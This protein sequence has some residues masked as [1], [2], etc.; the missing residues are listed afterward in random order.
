MCVGRRRCSS[1]WRSRSAPDRCSLRTRARGS[2]PNNVPRRPRR[3]SPTRVAGS[4]G[5]CSGS[6]RPIR[7]AGWRPTTA[8][9]FSTAT[10]GSR[11]AAAS[12]SAPAGA[13]TSSIATRGWTSAAASRPATTRCCRR[14]SRC[15]TWPATA[16]SS[17][18]MPSIA[19]TRRKISGESAL[20]SSPDTRRVSFR[21]DY[22][23]YEGRAIV[24]PVQLAR[25]R[26]ALRAPATAR[27]GA[28]T[29]S[30]LPVDPGC[31]ARARPRRVSTRSRTLTPFAEVFGAVDYRDQESG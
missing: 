24:R 19:T 17:A 6:R 12:G 10:S 9:T 5:R 18:C 2:S 11:S 14:T 8:S 20:E 26:H 7:S 21:V 15:P 3:S 28:G 13:T 1:C 30:A 22:T 31:A 16:S 29:D 25:G 23:D 4:N 27:S